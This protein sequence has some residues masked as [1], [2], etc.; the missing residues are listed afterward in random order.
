MKFFLSI[1]FL[2]GL[3]GY[4]YPQSIYT[5]NDDKIFI[6]SLENIITQTK[7]DSIKCFNLFKLSDLF[8]RNK[9]RE[10]SEACLKRANA[11]APRLQFLLDLSA[12]YNA[13]EYLKTGDFEGYEKQL[14]MANKKL[15]KYKTKPVYSLRGFILKNLSVLQ[16]MKNNEKESTRILIQEAIPIAKMGDDFEVLSSIYTSLGIVFMNNDDRAKAQD[17]LKIAINYAEKPGTQSYRLLE[18]RLHA[19]ICYAENATQLNKTADAQNSLDKAFHVLKNYPE[20]NLNAI[21]YH[22][23]GLLYFGLADFEKAIISYDRGIKNAKLHQDLT[24]LQNME[25]IKSQSLSNLGRYA[26]ARDLVLNIVE[27]SGQNIQD[28]QKF[29][30]IIIRYSEKMND[31]KTSYAYSKKYMGLT[32]SLYKTNTKK[33]ITELE[34]KYNA[35]E[36]EKKIAQLEVQN[37]NAI[38][39]SEKSKLNYKLFGL[40]AVLLLLIVLSLWKNASSQKNIAIEREKNYAQTLKNLRSQKELEVLQASISGEEEERKRIARDLHDGIGSRLSALKMR[41]VNKETLHP[42]ERAQE[43]RAVENL[44]NISISE[45][46]Q[47]AYNLI[48]ET[49]LKLG[50]EHALRDLCH[51]LQTETVSITFQASEITKTMQETNQIAIFRIIQELI[52]N[53]LKHSECS[54]IILDCSQNESLFLITVEDNG[55][56]FNKEELESF[57]GLG[58]RNVKNRINLLNGKLEIETAANKGTVFNIELSV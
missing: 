44:L 34:A 41:L 11:I 54:E 15:E 13:A 22:A 20:S 24:I 21:F 33:E 50:L 6:D 27:K 1:L 57:S 5:L 19:Y 26:E 31:L 45:L 4:L 25:F 18:T 38:L 16:Q 12:Y 56:G 9:N 2:A 28:R 58:F 47:V 10:L 52:N 17:Y 3:S 37:Q 35:A 7:S 39:A 29:Y 14:I 36:K 46:R 48:P 30:R 8:R 49:L 23:Q 53:A 32:D 51:T 55:I 42:E 40:F 43:A